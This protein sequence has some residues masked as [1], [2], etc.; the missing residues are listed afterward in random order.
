MALFLCLCMVAACTKLNPGRS[1][2][3]D[4]AGQTARQGVE[5]AREANVLLQ[6]GEQMAAAMA[7]LT[8]AQ[9]LAS[10]AVSLYQ[11]GKAEASTDATVLVDYGDALKL[12]GDLDLAALAY[13]SATEY[14]PSNA[15]YWLK[16]GKTRVLLGPTHTKS[17]LEA[18]DRCIK[19]IG[20]ADDANLIAQ[21]HVAQGDVYW[22]SQLYELAETAYT[23]SVA[24]ISD[25]AP[26][27]LGLA[28]LYARRGEVARAVTEIEGIGAIAR[29]FQMLLSQR[30]SDALAQMHRDRMVFSDTAGDHLAYAKLLS[31]VGLSP[32]ILL[33]LERSIAL[34]E[35]NYVAWNMLGSISAQT[36]DPERARFAFTRSLELK[37]DQEF[38]RMALDRV[39]VVQE[40]DEKK[41]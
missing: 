28:G 38:T 3:L 17:A 7:L 34:D 8:E 16:L 29:E 31:R 35:S 23:Q 20:P 25:Y 40:T 10:E 26:G 22:R 13:A 30:L 27:H 18:L 41:D 4:A 32:Q 1:A 9:A 21:A 5:K 37:P 12:T 14:A 33:A 39:S 24:A 6:E 36:G 15:S 2:A 11:D 19:S